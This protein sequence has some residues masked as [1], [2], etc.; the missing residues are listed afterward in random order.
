MAQL[1]ERILSMDEVLGSIPGA[2]TIF[3]LGRYEKFNLFK[4]S[5]DIKPCLKL[6]YITKN[7]FFKYITIM[8][9][10]LVSPFS[11]RLNVAHTFPEELESIASGIASLC[12]IRSRVPE[13]NIFCF[14]CED[15]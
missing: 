11:V 10:E 6:C 5:V 15:L 2:S 9:Y 3:C 8:D 7:Y 1:V 4:G 14:L 12:R 13:K